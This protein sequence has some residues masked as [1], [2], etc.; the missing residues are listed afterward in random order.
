MLIL[1]KQK[2]NIDLRGFFNLSKGK[3]HHLKLLEASGKAC[4]SFTRVGDNLMLCLDRGMR[5]K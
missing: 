3:V 5:G 4:F 1:T 2:D